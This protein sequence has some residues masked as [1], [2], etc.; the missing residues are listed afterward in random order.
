VHPKTKLAEAMIRVVSTCG[1][2][3]ATI[4]KV[5]EEA[6]VSPGIFHYHYLSKESL[7]KAA[8]ELSARKLVY[9]IGQRETED[10]DI[11]LLPSFCC[12]MVGFYEG[13][14]NE[15]LAVHHKYC[16]SD[17]FRGIVDRYEYPWPAVKD[18]WNY[19]VFLWSS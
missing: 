18:K 13:K 5:A 6:E 17:L 1:Y 15:F 19:L 9:T 7:F 16:I 4:K 12:L 2:H 14:F 10:E 11:V 3:R 8:M